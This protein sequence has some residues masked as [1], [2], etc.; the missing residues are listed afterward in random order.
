MDFFLV[1]PRGFICFSWSPA[2]PEDSMSVSLC[3]FI[4]C[5]NWPWLGQHNDSL[6]TYI[7]LIWWWPQFDYDFLLL[8][9]GPRSYINQI[10][11]W[12]QSWGKKSSQLISRENNFFFSPFLSFSSWGL[13]NSLHTLP[14]SCDISLSVQIAKLSR[15]PLVYIPE[16]SQMTRPTQ[17]YW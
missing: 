11:F 3:M 5:M 7:Y 1:L 4:L 13:R 14:F 15:L 16:P 12:N 10:E 9:S 8:L 6:I 2:T 17:R